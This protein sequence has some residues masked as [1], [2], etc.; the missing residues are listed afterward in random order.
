MKE[1]IAHRH[2]G[3]ITR[4]SQNGRDKGQQVINAEDKKIVCCYRQQSH[5]SLKTDTMIINTHVAMP[6]LGIAARK[7][8]AHENKYSS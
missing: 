2:E 3:F 1:C 6:K 5:V 7:D 8:Q 4:S